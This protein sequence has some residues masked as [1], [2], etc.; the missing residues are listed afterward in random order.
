M[1]FLFKLIQIEDI[2]TPI[3]YDNDIQYH[4]KSKNLKFY[5][6]HTNPENIKNFINESYCEINLK[7][8]KPEISNNF[9]LNETYTLTI[10]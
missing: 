6:N 10:D 9:K 8:L 1:K 2:E 3:F 5:L 4:I 7:N